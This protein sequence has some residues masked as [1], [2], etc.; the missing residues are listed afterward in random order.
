[1]T[2]LLPAAAL[3][4]AAAAAFAAPAAAL[5]ISASTSPIAPVA[6]TETVIGIQSQPLGNANFG[7]TGAAGITWTLSFGT[8]KNQGVVRGAQ[9]GQF[10]IP[11]AG[12]TPAAP[13][14]LTGDFGSATTPTEANAGKYLSTGIG[15]ITL[16]FGAD[17]S[18]FLMLWGSIDAYNSVKFFNDGAQVGSTITGSAVA[19]LAGIPAAN[20]NRGFGG[21]A[22]VLFSNIT[23]DRIDFISTQ[24]SFE[25]AALVGSTQPFAVPVPG[26][27]ALF[28]AGLMGLGMVARKRRQG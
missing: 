17:Q 27:L 22:Y 5:N 6:G 14:F 10:A 16:S 15:T 9:S 20:G 25:F 2:R 13:L 21:S 23:F 4:A 8:P 12:G 7:G 28:G 26:A 1:M 19:P 18:A 3:V 11:V 24:N